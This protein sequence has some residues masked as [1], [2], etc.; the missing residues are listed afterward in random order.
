LPQ[1][2]PAEALS[3][4]ATVSSS[5]VNPGDQHS[6]TF[7]GTAAQRIYFDALNRQFA[8]IYSKL[9]GPNGQIIWDF[10]AASND[11]GPLALP[12]AGTYTLLIDGSSGTTGT[13]A[14][15]LLDL[16]TA[17]ALTIGSGT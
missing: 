15:R 14:F 1:A 5:I 9:T 13:Y 16:G 17:P 8:Q 3:F 2:I 4:G 6:Y 10:S 7:S 12:A 11:Q